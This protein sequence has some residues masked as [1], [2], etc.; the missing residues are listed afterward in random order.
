MHENVELNNLEE[1]CMIFKNAISDVNDNL[2]LLKDQPWEGGH[3]K[4]LENGER[5]KNIDDYKEK[6]TVIAVRLDDFI[7][8][9]NF[10]V[11]TYIKVDIDG[12][13]LNFIDGAINVL[14]NIKKIHIELTDDNKDIIIEKFKKLNLHTEK[15]YDV[16]SISG[17]K[18]DGLY[19][20]VFSK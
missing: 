4:I 19:N 6:E 10:P 7:E 18:Y 17:E 14:S 5:V 16:Y 11:P 13:E 20:Y 1:T 2:L 12:N 15:I 3:L 9:N 8:K